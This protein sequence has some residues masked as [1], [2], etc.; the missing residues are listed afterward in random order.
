MGK[1]ESFTSASALPI[2]LFHNKVKDETGKIIPIHPQIYLTN[3]CN[4]KCKFCSCADRDKTKEISFG[5]AI[6]ILDF[7]ADNGTKAITLSGGGEPMMYKNIDDI[8]DYAESK[9]IEIGLVSNGILIDKLKNHKN[10]IW[11]R[12]SS[13]DDRIPSYSNILEA[14][15]TNRHTD[16]SFS[17]VVTRYPN[18]NT[19]EDIVKFANDNNFSH[20]RLV[21]DL[22]DLK[23]SGLD[24]VE[25]Y[26]KRNK[27]NDSKVIYQGRK[28]FTKGNKKCLIS[29][30]KP[31]ITPDGI[32]PCCG[33]QYAINGQKKS[34]VDEMKMGEL[35]DLK[36]I[37]KK[38]KNFDGSVCDR[39]YYNDY[40]KSL[41]AIQNTPKHK[42]FI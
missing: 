1:L 36:K 22:N 28:E 17:H 6:E 38:Q 41:N 31:V 16:W 37:I 30:L 8:I 39:C 40:N 5:K 27:I 29:L 10:L 7:L 26:I 15:K 24:C 14:L 13:S 32:F 3:K 4:L 18:K 19:I 25:R 33:S 42:N 23:F 20:I 11:S 9:N 35:K 2:K 12:M 21:A 34:L